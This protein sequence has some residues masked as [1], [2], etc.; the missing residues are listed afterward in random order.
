MNNNTV[1]TIADRPPSKLHR[2]KDHFTAR[3][4]FARSAFNDR[5]NPILAKTPVR[6]QQAAKANVP[7]N[8][9]WAVKIGERVVGM[10][11]LVQDGPQSAEIV[12]FRIDPEWSHTK[13]P[14]N[15]IRS[16]ESFCQEHGRL[17]VFMQPHTVPTW[18]LTLMNQHGILLK[19]TKQGQKN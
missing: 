15:L 9:L 1:G 6:S 11:R 3:S 13:V 4:Q 8:F 7:I 12:L 18:I 5:H 10:A 16:I 17:S 19:E 2:A 14:L